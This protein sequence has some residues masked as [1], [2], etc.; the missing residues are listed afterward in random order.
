MKKL[1]SVIL[2]FCFT[3]SFS[4]CSANTD[5]NSNSPTKE[6]V[7]INLPNDNSV[8]GYRVKE[9]QKDDTLSMPDQIKQ[10]D[11]NIISGISNT[12][13]NSYAYCG[14]KNSKVFHTISC[15]SLSDMKDK[16][17]VFSSDRNSLI[18]QGYHP[19]NR[20]KP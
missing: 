11:T 15:G 20:C 7:E 1:F 19:C 9:P 6:K 5:N 12:D 8:N 10:D 3:L 13:S 2:I 14:N 17:K 18:S 16:N 4:G